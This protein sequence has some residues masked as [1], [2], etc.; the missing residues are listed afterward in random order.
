MK[1]LICQSEFRDIR[2]IMKHVFFKHKGYT[3]K[4]Y[5]D[6]FLRKD[7]EGICECGQETTF[8]GAGGGYLEFCSHAC[9]SSSEKTRLNISSKAS[10][11]KQSQETIR[12]RVTNTDQLRKEEKR[13]ATSFEKY[14]V[15]NPSKSPE[16][17]AKIRASNAGKPRPRTDEHTRKIAESRRINGTNRHSDLTKKKISNSIL[18]S[19]KFQSRKEDGTFVRSSTLSNGR[20]LCGK[21]KGLHFR[22]S[23]ELSFLIEM[24][25]KNVVVEPADN[26]SFAC[27]YSRSDGKAS[28]YYPD[29]FLSETQE[30][31]E[32]KNSSLC[33][34]QNNMLKFEVAESKYGSSFK[35]LT[36]FDLLNI[37]SIVNLPEIRDH[38]E[39][40]KNEHLCFKS[41]S[42][43]GGK[44]P[45][46]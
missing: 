18:N 19:K 10:G 39:I 5:Y 4:S 35:V 44:R 41:K 33:K 3:P 1:C 32:I 17:S 16:V 30:V 37:T 45:L 46:R 2:S 21:F 9:Y 11:R 36:E 43:L 14:G 31:V 26:K 6:E 23:Y 22:S 27:S 25:L 13:R 8:R 42:G 7:D 28:R 15:S 40:L 20:T 34:L 24:H 38:L 12:K 29:F